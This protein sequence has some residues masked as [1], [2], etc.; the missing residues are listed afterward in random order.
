M[1]NQETRSVCMH[2]AHSKKTLYTSYWQGGWGIFTIS[3]LCNEIGLVLVS[4]VRPFCSAV[5]IISNVFMC[6]ILKVIG[7]VE[8]SLLVRGSLVNSS[9]NSVLISYWWLTRGVTEMRFSF[10]KKSHWN[11]NLF[12]S[13]CC[14]L[15]DNTEPGCIL[16]IV[17]NY[18]QINWTDSRF[19]LLNSLTG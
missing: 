16:G 1:L 9:R 8:H 3:D 6:L 12:H 13:I 10:T 4:Q 17:P 7:A 2:L 11:L 14:G 19:G 5:K 18:G 15:W